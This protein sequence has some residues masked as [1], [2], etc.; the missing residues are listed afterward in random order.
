MGLLLLAG[1]LASC[2]KDPKDI[3]PAVTESPDFGMEANFGNEAIDIAAGTDQ[4]TMLPVVDHQD[5]L[6]VFTAIFSKDGCLDQCQSSWTF[7]FFQAL[8]DEA[9]P[10]IDFTNTIKPGEKQLVLSD[11]ELD[12]FDIQLSTHPG[13]FMSGFSFWDD[14]TGPTTYFPQFGTVLGYQDSLGVCF[15]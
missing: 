2:V 14:L 15:Q 4:W 8:P 11:Q 6:D 9:D 7:H 10:A 12:S 1:S 5:S 3:P 13:L